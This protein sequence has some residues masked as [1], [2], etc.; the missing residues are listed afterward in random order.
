[1]DGKAR[2]AKAQALKAAGR[3]LEAATL[4]RMVPQPLMTAQPALDFCACLLRIGRQ[5]EARPWLDLLGR[6]AAREPALQEALVTLGFELLAD[7]LYAEGWPLLEFRVGLNDDLIPRIAPSYPEWRGE[8]VAGR[9]I[10]VWVEQG[11]GDQIMLARFAAALADRGAGVTLACRPPLARLFES[12]RGVRT[13][14][15]VPVGGTTHAPRHDLWTRYFSIPGRL[16]TTLADLPAA[17]YLAAPAGGGAVAGDARFGFVWRTSGTGALAAQKMLPPELAA[18]LAALGGLSLD[19][20][21]TGAADFADTAALIAQ[22]PL[23]ITAD[24]AVAHLAGAMG[25]PV[26]VLLHHTADWR[27]L[28]RR[29]DSPWYPTAR[30]FRQPEPGD[31]TSVVRDVREALAAG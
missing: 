27:W 11:Y 16:G 28:K 24:T 18:E 10:L 30:L 8:P 4:Y 14:L 25:K 19:P 5:Q 26:W 31:W 29:A 1:M 3:H 9:S 23:V 7:G 22:L 2:I 17:P 20:E 15:A 6:N 21:D 13:V 12:L